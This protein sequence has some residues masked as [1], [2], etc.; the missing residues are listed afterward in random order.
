MISQNSNK[1]LMLSVW[2]AL[3]VMAF[4]APHLYAQEGEDNTLSPYFVVA[5]K[6]TVSDR[7]P[8]KQTSA[9]VRISGVI[10]DVTVRQRYCNEGPNVLEAIYVFP[11][12]SRAAVYGMNM[13][14]GNRILY[15][16]IMEKA[17]ARELYEEAKEE[18][19]TTTLLE[20]ER[21]NVFRMNVGNILPGDTIDIEMK[22]TELL[23]PVEGQY[24]FVYPTV[25]GPRYVSPSEDSASSAFAGVPYT[26]EGEAPLYDF[27]IN[28]EI[29]AG[30]SLKEMR[31]PSHDSVR[32]DL[33]GDHATCELLSK[34]EGERDFILQ[35]R[36]SGD[37]LESGLLLFEGEEENFFLAMIQ[38]PAIP[39]DADIPPREYVF[40][41]DVSGSMSGFPIEI[42]KTLLSDLVSH[43][44]ETDRFN[45]LFFAGGSQLLAMASLPATYE[46]RQLAIEM[47]DSR[48]GGGGTQ[49]LSALN[50]ALDLEGTEGF[51]RSFVI[52]TD[53]YV[54]VERQSFDLIR[55]R[56]G[57]A[58]FFPF[59][60]GSSV[61]RFIIEG[62]A[63][64]GMTEPLIVTK[65]EEAAGMA[66]KFRQYIQYP[67]LTNIT[68]EFNGFEV[69][70]VE[71]LTVP[72][73]MAQRPVIIF[74]KWRGDPAGEINLSG[75]TG[76]MLY[77]ESLNV[78]HFT[79]MAENSAL[80][81]LW[82]RKRIQLLSDYARLN[83]YGEVDSALIEE[84]TTLG[85]EYNLLTEYTSFI[86]VDSLIRNEGD[87][88]TTVVQPLPMPLG[89]PDEAIGDGGY[90]NNPVSY[91][92]YGVVDQTLIMECYP[93]PFSG[94]VTFAMK[95]RKDDLA[96]GVSLEV[97]DVMGKT[98][99]VHRLSGLSEG[100]NEVTL[101][102]PGLIP[103][104]AH[105][106]YFARIS[107]G[108]RQSAFVKIVY[109]G[110]G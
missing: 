106:F 72:D 19:K 83:S 91:A 27:S 87:S 105:G 61:N 22:Y 54:T 85:L 103:G 4:S 15:A 53:G 50:R 11:A 46:N 68:T 39:V 89:V 70:D 93:N 42:S 44:R 51:S 62:M 34:R 104:M 57:E 102:L 29:N 10:A 59:G 71:P 12:S 64:V 3:T 73:V 8:L 97:M 65:S 1:R 24:E 48:Q 41:M 37:G 74:G 63:H 9:E 99:C 36:L 35:Y 45:V 107:S 49:L 110:G 20:Q 52:A 40:I 69:Y 25:V 17:D 31:C 2:L 90:R 101:D 95:L 60:I 38:P 81:Y 79:P 94:A 58:N 16:K 55:N 109:Q 78:A 86:A 76:D 77:E 28:V 66:D 7:L 33:S 14:I 56:L 26:H 82:A 88:I 84:V 13:I 18:G 80:R 67:V 75:T 30:I 47:I 92:Q 23:V 6:D 5:C 21:P 43:I 108:D 98:I 100:L 96:A 32:V